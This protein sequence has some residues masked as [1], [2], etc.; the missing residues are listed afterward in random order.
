[1]SSEFKIGARVRISRDYHWAQNAFGTLHL[2]PKAV[3]ELTGGWNVGFRE[4]VSMKGRFLFY[5]VRFDES[6]IDPEGDGP[7][8]E[9]EIDCRYLELL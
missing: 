6:Q 1:M 2:P 3:I 4:F 5:W 8:E 9:A 7:H